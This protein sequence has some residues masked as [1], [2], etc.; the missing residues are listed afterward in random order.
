MV[1]DFGGTTHAPIVATLS[2]S[3]EPCPPASYCTPKELAEVKAQLVTLS[4]QMDSKLLDLDANIS[5]ASRL[6]YLDSNTANN[7][8]MHIQGK[9]K[10]EGLDSVLCIS[11]SNTLLSSSQVTR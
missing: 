4:A 3:A 8:T 11:A 5:F 7:P 9:E 10:F 6:L 2:P 1:R